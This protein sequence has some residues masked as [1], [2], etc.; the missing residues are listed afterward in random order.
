MRDRSTDGKLSAA[1]P[2]TAVS[3]FAGAGGLDCGGGAAGRDPG[4]G[5]L[6]WRCRRILRIA[7]QDSRSDPQLGLPRDRRKLRGAVGRGGRGLR[8]RLR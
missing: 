1:K 6:H 8:M 3:L 5:D 2:L 4:S 7:G